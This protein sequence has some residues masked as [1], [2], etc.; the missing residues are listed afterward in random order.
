MVELVGGAGSIGWVAL[1]AVLLYV[2]AV[3][4]FRVARRRTIAEMSP[5]DFVAAIAVGAIIGRVPNADTTSYL[6]GDATLVTI[7]VA[8]AV[9]TRLRRHRAVRDV[10]DP[11]P[12]LLVADGTVLDRPLRASGLTRSDLDEL[13]RLRG[14]TDLR[15][16]RYAIYEARG[17]ITVVRRGEEIGEL[18]RHVVDDEAVG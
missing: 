13:L 7:L 10:V 15:D 14:V 8:H 12:R 11:A 3:A 16:V 4:G 5:Y 9:V 2:T 17:R 6:A 1:K 18:V